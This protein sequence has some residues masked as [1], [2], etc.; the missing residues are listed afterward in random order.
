MLKI[1]TMLKFKSF[2]MQ[3]KRKKNYAFDNNSY[4]CVRKKRLLMKK[5]LYMLNLALAAILLLSSC[6]DNESVEA[7]KLNNETNFD[8]TRY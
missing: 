8:L 7:G 1:N 4:L 2:F 5:M 3:N 6:R